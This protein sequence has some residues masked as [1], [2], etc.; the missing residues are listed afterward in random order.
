MAST[1]GSFHGSRGSFHGSVE[2]SVEASI[3][4]HRKN[5]RAG[6]RESVSTS[7]NTRTD[8]DIILQQ[9]SSSN[10]RIIT[11]VC[12]RTSSKIKTHKNEN[13]TARHIQVQ[14]PCDWYW[15]TLQLLLPL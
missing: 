12:V 14:P 9:Y 11:A 3:D 1:E 10:T 8:T 4:F 7:I 15:Y 2:A 6:G 5:N 13:A